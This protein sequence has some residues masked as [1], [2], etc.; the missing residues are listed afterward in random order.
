MKPYLAKRNWIDKLL[1]NWVISVRWLRRCRGG[2]KD[3]IK[4]TYSKC[5]HNMS[6]QYCFLHGEQIQKH[7]ICMRHYTAVVGRISKDKGRNDTL[8]FLFCAYCSIPVSALCPVS[9]NP[10][11][12]T[13]AKATTTIPAN[14]WDR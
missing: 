10:N 12:Q 13:L 14:T 7:S 11:H 2:R 8:G 9:V 3:K 1:D 4:T 5:T 6:N